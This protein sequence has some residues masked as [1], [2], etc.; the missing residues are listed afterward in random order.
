ME[1]AM[2]EVTITE[3]LTAIGD[4]QIQFQNLDQCAS[5][6]DWTLKSGGKITFGTD[7]E[8]IPGEGTKQ[9][10]LV[11]WIDRDAARTALAAI[12]KGNDHE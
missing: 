6:L 2:S 11:V 4:D 12:T 10:G 1:I 8:I 9:L 5:R 7:Q 3:L